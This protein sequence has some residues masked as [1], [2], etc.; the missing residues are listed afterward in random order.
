MNEWKES[1]PPPEECPF[2]PCWVTNGIN[3]FMASW[4]RG[5][6]WKVG[7]GAALNGEWKIGAGLAFSPD[8]ITHYQLLQAPEPPNQEKLSSIKEVSY[9]QL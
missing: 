3:V 8:E 6:G 5:E 7:T 9:A 1:P 2:Y 4:R